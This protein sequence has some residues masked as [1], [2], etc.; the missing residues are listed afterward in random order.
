EGGG[1]GDAL[2]GLYFGV[3]GDGDA[4]GCGEGEDRVG[5]GVGWRLGVGRD[6]CGQEKDGGDN[7]VSHGRLV[8][9]CWCKTS[10]VS[11]RSL[12]RIGGWAKAVV[13]VW[14][15]RK[16]H[17]KVAFLNKMRVGAGWK[18]DVGASPGLVVDEAPFVAGAGGVHGDE[19]IAGFERECL[20]VAGREFE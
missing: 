19:D 4:E 20:A 17:L 1:V 9:V 6:L 2:G 11:R 14:N 3:V 10:D 18:D 7:W 16:G 13:G 5:D 15:K 12:V 8:F